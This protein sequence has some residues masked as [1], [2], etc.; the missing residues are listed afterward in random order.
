MTVYTGKKLHRSYA[1]L[2]AVL[3]TSLM[4]ASIGVATARYRQD[5][6]TSTVYGESTETE[7]TLDVERRVYDFGAWTTGG[8][9]P[10]AI[11]VLHQSTPLNGGLRFTLDDTSAAKRDISVFTEWGV[12]GSD[13]LYA[14]NDQ[15]GHAELPFSLLVATSTRS[16]VVQLD[17]E[18]IPDGESE[19]TLSARYLLTLNPHELCADVEAPPAIG[20]VTEFLTDEQLYLSLQPPATAAGLILANGPTLTDA[21]AAGLCYH[22]PLYPQGVTLLQDSTIY[23]PTDGSDSQELLLDFNRSLTE[24]V[25]LTAGVSDGYLATTTQ[26]PTDKRATLDVVTEGVPL[27]NTA[28]LWSVT[29]KETAAFRDAVWNNGVQEGAQLTVK[30]RRLTNGAFVDVSSNEDLVLSFT[31]T[32]NGGTVTVAAPTGVQPAGTYQL[33]FTQTWNGYP[34]FAESVPFF[35]DYR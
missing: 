16:G 25:R 11:I 8:Q 21:F 5:P 3:L 17:V 2:C 1:V 4:I 6:L 30:M 24:P 13:G 7:T 14:V 29:V 22:T 18:W 26:T 28:R 12:K 15:D 19:P 31:Q 20:N 32:E 33:V 27:V 34:L 10:A 23:L 35:I 9:D